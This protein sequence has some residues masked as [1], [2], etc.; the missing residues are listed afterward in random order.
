[1][2]DGHRVG[3]M[4]YEGFKH[5]LGGVRFPP[6]I[7]EY[8]YLALGGDHVN[9]HGFLL[10]ESPA[11]ANRLVVLLPRV[12][13]ERHDVSAMLPVQSEATDLGLCDKPLQLP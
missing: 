5:P 8:A 2:I 10:P 11:S 12:R 13:R 3:H 9:V 6:Q 1:M 4:L 7:G